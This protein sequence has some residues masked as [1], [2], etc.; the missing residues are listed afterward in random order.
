MSKEVRTLRKRKHAR[1]L[2]KALREKISNAGT[3]EDAAALILSTLRAG[4]VFDMRGLYGLS[5]VHIERQLRFLVETA[6]EV[7]SV[8]AD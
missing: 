1:L 4:T 3:V 2:K 6:L 8:K 7:A 5:P